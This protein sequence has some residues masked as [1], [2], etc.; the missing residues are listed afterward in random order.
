MAEEATTEAK[1]RAGAPGAELSA[2]LR[3]DSLP[4]MGTLLPPAP[5][6]EPAGASCDPTELSE[7]DSTAG[8]GQLRPPAEPGG[9]LSLAAA[10]LAAQ[11]DR[12]LSLI[13]EAQ[14]RSWQVHPLH[15]HRHDHE[16]FKTPGVSPSAEPSLNPT[17]VSGTVHPPTATAAPPA[18]HPPPP[19]RTAA[20]PTGPPAG[21]A[22]TAQPG[23]P[24][25]PP[26]GPHRGCRCQQWQQQCRPGGLAVC[27]QPW[28]GRG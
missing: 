1:E 9:N 16:T 8:G 17:V 6:S 25:A 13:A 5:C 3:A 22:A 4:C 21:A 18:D 14:G 23:V 28:P 24:P 19:P 2:L 11:N 20:V 12:R 15:L 27:R 26:A 7:R 10:S